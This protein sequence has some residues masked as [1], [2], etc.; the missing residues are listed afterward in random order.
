MPFAPITRVLHQ[1]QEDPAWDEMQA[2]Q[3]ILQA[4]DAVVGEI[5]ARQAQPVG[6]IPGNKLQVAVA[7]GA[8]AQT[9]MFER[10]RILGK[11]NQHLKT[12]LADICFSQRGWPVKIK[13]FDRS[14]SNAPHTSTRLTRP[15][16]AQPASAQAAF[17]QW[18]DSVQK[19]SQRLPLC[20]CCACPTPRPELDLWRMCGLCSVRQSR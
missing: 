12:P 13:R 10:L 16:P 11:L 2:F 18:S 9:L 7:S 4:W 3:V 17:Q 1:L 19:F 15:T 20:P 6:I 5:V 14:T 8:W